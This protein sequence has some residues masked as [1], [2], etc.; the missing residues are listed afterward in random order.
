MMMRMKN[1]EE[2]GEG[3]YR[4]SRACL[5]EIEDRED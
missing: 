4:V 2:I 1:G 3:I 5:A